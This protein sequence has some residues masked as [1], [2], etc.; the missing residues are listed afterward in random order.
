MND[1]LMNDYERLCS[2]FNHFELKST[3]MNIILNDTK[4]FKNDSERSKICVVNFRSS[5]WYYDMS[6]YFE[7]F[8]CYEIQKD[9]RLD[10]FDVHF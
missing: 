4:S 7:N 5:I 9:I 6:I 2:I 8:K 3:K 1:N 10:E